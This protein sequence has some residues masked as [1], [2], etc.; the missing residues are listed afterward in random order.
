MNVIMN[1]LVSNAILLV[2]GVFMAFHTSW[3]LSVLAICVIPPVG[4]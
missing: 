3:K 4:A 1:D 2:G